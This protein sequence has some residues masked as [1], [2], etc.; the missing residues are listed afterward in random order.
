MGHLVAAACVLLL[1]PALEVTA[2]S[3]GGW[4]PDDLVQNEPVYSANG[5]YCAIV[6]WYDVAD[7]HSERAGKVFH[8]DPEYGSDEKEP[9]P[10]PTHVTVAWYEV[11][12]AGPRRI[13]EVSI[14]RQMTQ[15]LLADSGRYLAAVRRIHGGYCY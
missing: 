5:R 2:C 9:V 4:N 11:T 10:A 14:P 12:A 1:F 13:A 3:T 7:F 8:L 15:I 6:R